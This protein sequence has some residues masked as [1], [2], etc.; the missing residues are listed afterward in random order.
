[1][2]PEAS[3]EKVCSR[4][5]T[6]D[7]NKKKQR[8]SCEPKRSTN[9]S[10]QHPVYQEAPM[11][12]NFHEE[13]PKYVATGRKL[14]KMT[15]RFCCFCATE[16]RKHSKTK[17]PRVEVGVACDGF[18]VSPRKPRHGQIANTCKTKIPKVGVGIGCD[19]FDNSTRKRGQ[20]QFAKKRKTKV[21]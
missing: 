21:P 14:P 12:V 20:D 15:L 13:P 19:N 18:E 8:G 17:V 16:S 10:S 11:R 7:N 6:L 9:D 2:P 4:N 1:M 5:A 3:L